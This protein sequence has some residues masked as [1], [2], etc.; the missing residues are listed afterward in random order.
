ML[1]WWKPWWNA[2]GQVSHRFKLPRNKKSSIGQSWKPTNR[3]TLHPCLLEIK[4]W[5][6]SNKQRQTKSAEFEHLKWLKNESIL[7]ELKCFKAS[8]WN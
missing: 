7:F 3:E 8:S 5:Y 1:L 4:K 2:M 6:A